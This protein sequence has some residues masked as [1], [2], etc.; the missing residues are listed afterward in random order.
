MRVILAAPS[1]PPGPTKPETRVL[2]AVKS[3]DPRY[4]PDG[5]KSGKKPKFHTNYF[6]FD[7]IIGYRGSPS[8]RRN[9]QHRGSPIPRQGC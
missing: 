4:G 2:A 1:P 9:I 6:F 5:E 7:F 3:L 8:R